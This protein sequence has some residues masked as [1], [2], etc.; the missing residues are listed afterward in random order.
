[1]TDHAAPLSA[2]PTSP[3]IQVCTLD[4]DQVCI[5]CGR[6][7]D[8]VIAWTRLTDAQKWVVLTQSAQRKAQREQHLQ[9]K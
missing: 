9:L 5:G 1:M 4:D 2:K 8:E 3:C 7:I 6:N